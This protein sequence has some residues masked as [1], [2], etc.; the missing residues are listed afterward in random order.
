MDQTNNKHRNRN[1]FNSSRQVPH[2]L[3]WWDHLVF[4]PLAVE[5]LSGPCF[6]C[7][8]GHFDWIKS[9]PMM[10]FGLVKMLGG[11]IGYMLNEH[12]CLFIEADC[13]PLLR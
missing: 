10:R 9:P 8:M 5:V 2:L 13:G 3:Q 1:R 11:I 4:V 12:L 7:A 6:S